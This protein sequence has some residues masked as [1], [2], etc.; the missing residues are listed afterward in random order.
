MGLEVLSGDVQEHD[1]AV[2]R[3]VYQVT[4]VDKFVRG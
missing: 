2:R 1:L 3:S 4:I